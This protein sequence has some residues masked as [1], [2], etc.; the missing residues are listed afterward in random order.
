MVCGKTG[1][2]V[3]RDFPFGSW[4]L[5]LHDGNLADEE[6]STTKSFCVNT[7]LFFGPC[8]L[9]EGSNIALHFA[10][11]HFH[12]LDLSLS[13]RDGLEVV[14]LRSLFLNAWLADVVMLMSAG[15]FCALGRRKLR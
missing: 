1:C 13:P 9:C 11:A 10:L 15:G 12:D 2:F 7:F 5:A 4:D 14:P 8:L 3:L 6:E